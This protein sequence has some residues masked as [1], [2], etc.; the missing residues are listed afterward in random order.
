MVKILIEEGNAD[1]DAAGEGMTPL[2][3]ATWYQN[4]EL[5]TYLIGAGASVNAQSNSLFNESILFWAIQRHNTQAATLLLNF[6]NVENDPCTI[7]EKAFI[8][9]FG[10]RARPEKKKP[11]MFGMFSRGKDKGKGG[12]GGRGGG[13][14]R[15]ASSGSRGKSTPKSKSRSPTPGLQSKAPDKKKDNISDKVDEQENE[16]DDDDDAS[17]GE[18]EEK[19]EVGVQPDLP[20]RNGATPLLLLMRHSQVYPAE[21]KLPL[22]ELLIARGASVNVI[23][24]DKMTPLLWAVLNVQAP[25][26]KLLLAHGM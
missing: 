23:S 15:S 14:A 26:V 1:I 10:R 3:W 25:L 22:A 17:S 4:I 18:E 2:A 12:K 16:N 9:K 19:K 20:C 8:A 6:R 5:M 21:E 13:S 11:S 7:A 24:T